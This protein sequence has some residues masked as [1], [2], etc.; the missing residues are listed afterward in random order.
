MNANYGVLRAD[1]GRVRD[2]KEKKRLFGERALA[3]IE[4]FRA[5]LGE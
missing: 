2:K 1:F 4:R 3:E 5:E